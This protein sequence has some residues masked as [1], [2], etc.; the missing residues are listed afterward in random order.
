MKVEREGR[1]RVVDENTKE[2][3]PIEFQRVFPLAT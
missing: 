1:N 2:I 3:V